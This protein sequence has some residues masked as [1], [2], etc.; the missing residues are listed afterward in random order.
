[1]IL[2]LDVSS[3]QAQKPTATLSVQPLT[4]A[5]PPKKNIITSLPDLLLKNYNVYDKRY[6][7]VTQSPPG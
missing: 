7:K 6:S 4:R 3:D 2:G 5:P 1:M